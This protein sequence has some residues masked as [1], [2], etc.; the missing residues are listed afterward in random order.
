MSREY[1]QQESRSP[2]SIYSRKAFEPSTNIGT[3]KLHM[4]LSNTTRHSMPARSA[5]PQMPF[6]LR[7]HQRHS[8]SAAQV[9]S[10]EG[11]L[12]TATM[13]ARS[14]SMGRVK[15]AARHVVLLQELLTLPGKDE[16]LPM[17]T[18]AE[19]E[20]QSAIFYKASWSLIACHALSLV[21]AIHFLN[22]SIRISSVTFMCAP[23]ASS[24][25]RAP[26]SSSTLRPSQS[27]L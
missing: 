18:H 24:K 9:K 22:A 11:F 27:S 7:E 12:C 10:A 15:V 16:V 2:A 23:G 3:I 26:R 4:Q 21:G 6:A 14:V 19:T 8:E 13:S 5:K 17:R 1:I 25:N 20:H